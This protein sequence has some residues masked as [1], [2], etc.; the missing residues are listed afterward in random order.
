[1][2]CISGWMDTRRAQANFPVTFI[3]TFNLNSFF[4]HSQLINYVFIY[5]LSMGPSQLLLGTKKAPQIIVWSKGIFSL[6]L[7]SMGPG[8]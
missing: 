5:L 3:S 2:A 6:D 4:D 1:M 7:P 8:E